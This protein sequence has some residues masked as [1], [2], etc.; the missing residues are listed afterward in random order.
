MLQTRVN[1]ML[2]S[3]NILIAAGK[4]VNEW[5]PTPGIRLILNLEGARA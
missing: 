1:Q 2:G 5:T 3:S 4:R